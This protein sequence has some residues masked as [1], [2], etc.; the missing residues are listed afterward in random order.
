MLRRF[1]CLCAM[2]AVALVASTAS[3]NVIIRGVAVAGPNL[4]ALN[5]GQL[6]TIN[7]QVRVPVAVIGTD[8]DDNPINQTVNTAEFRILSGGGGNFVAPAT[9]N[10]ATADAGWVAFAPG[11]TNQLGSFALKAAAQVFT[12]NNQTRTIGT[13][14]L[15][16]TTPGT[17]NVSFSNLQVIDNDFQLIAG[18]TSQGFSYTVVPEPS[19][20]LL[21]GLALAGL[22]FR[23]RRS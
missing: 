6:V 8:P 5:P 18:Q 1:S 11:T 13:I 14:T 23:R 16:P 7:V 12:A 20:A 17:Y 3:A 21:G 22:A 9:T 19:S 10:A 2:L 4:N 15:N